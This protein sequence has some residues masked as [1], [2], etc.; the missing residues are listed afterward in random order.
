MRNRLFTITAALFCLGLLV[1]SRG[2]AQE[3]WRLLTEDAGG[4][5]LYLDEGAIEPLPE[6]ATFRVTFRFE[7]RKSETK[8]IFVDE[9][10]CRHTRVKRLSLKMLNPVCTGDSE[11]YAISFDGRWDA[12]S[13]GI[14]RQLFEAICR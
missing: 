4:N 12:V 3:R 13:E 9:I 6:A 2:S 8:M 7:L 11:T 14:E 1:P 5:R 10:D